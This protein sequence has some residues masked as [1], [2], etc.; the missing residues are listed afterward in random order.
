ME[1]SSAV[2]LT[3]LRADTIKR[4]VESIFFSEIA[5]FKNYFPRP[6]YINC[7]WVFAWKNELFAF[8][9]NMQ[10][11]SS[12]ERLQL[13]DALNVHLKV[14]SSWR[15]KIEALMG[16]SSFVKHYLEPCP[17]AIVGMQ[18]KY[19]IEARV[20]VILMKRLLFHIFLFEATEF[21]A[22][23]TQKCAGNN[24]NWLLS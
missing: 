21:E 22:S 24:K 1:Y 13:P 9:L 10:V 7:F 15:Q 17:T 20:K 18:F 19:D 16:F 14:F 5:S 11:Y 4:E 12:H 23:S 8:K 6:G 2:S 3:N